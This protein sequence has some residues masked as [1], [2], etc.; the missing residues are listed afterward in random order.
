MG[1][2]E[3]QSMAMDQSMGMD[4]NMFMPQQPM[5]QPVSHR[6]PIVLPSYL[7]LRHALPDPDE[8]FQLDYHLYTAPLPHV[9][10]NL[11]TSNPLHSFFIPDDIRRTFQA[12]HEATYLPVGPSPGIPS[13][14]GVYHSLVQLEG[15]GGPSRVYGH[16]APVY[17]AVSTVDGNVYCLRRI[18]G[19]WDSICCGGML[20]LRKES[21]RLESPECG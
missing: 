21:Q 9:S 8:P 6:R 1:Y 3:S 16:P 2:D 10:S 12:R 17:R 4:S 7:S 14:L 19:A 15:P 13:E 20:G 5:R 18:E 11:Q